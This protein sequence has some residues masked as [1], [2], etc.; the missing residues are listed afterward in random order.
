MQLI[1]QALEVEVGVGAKD[2]RPRL[3][4]RR[5]ALPN[6]FYARSAGGEQEH[7]LAFLRE[8]TLATANDA[9]LGLTS[10][11]VSSRVKAAASNG[12]DSLAADLGLQS[13]KEV[14]S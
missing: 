4:R 9:E 2:R 13:T 10:G 1:H 3:D 6:R 12:A 5:R 11:I 8:P 7:L 14:N